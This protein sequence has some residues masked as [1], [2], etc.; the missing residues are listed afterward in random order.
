MSSA[1]EGFLRAEN[2]GS[3][4]GKSAD[5]PSGG[6]PRNIYLGLR[7]SS[8]SSHCHLHQSLPISWT[9]II[10][11]CWAL[12]ASHDGDQT[13][14]LGLYNFHPEERT[15]HDLSASDRRPIALAYFNA[16]IVHGEVGL[17][18]DE[19]IIVV[20]LRSS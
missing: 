7:S 10:A 9:K 6:S 17:E 19:I 4:A 3:L 1:S 16:P 14:Q 5:G 15:P 18:E 20:E 12:V 8:A 11:P 13:S 2:G